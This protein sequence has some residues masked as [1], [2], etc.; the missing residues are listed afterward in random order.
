MSSRHTFNGI[1]LNFYLTQLL[2]L[3][4]VYLT[5]HN[6]KGIRIKFLQRKILVYHSPDI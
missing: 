3:A 1:T 2:E 4:N 6:L 5:L